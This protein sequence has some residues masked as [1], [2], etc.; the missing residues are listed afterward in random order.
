MNKLPQLDD[1]NLVWSSLIITSIIWLICIGSHYGND[2]LI[3]FVEYT[4]R[5]LQRH[6][7]K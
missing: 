6:N 2:A 5:R 1:A 4:S 7:L 3:C